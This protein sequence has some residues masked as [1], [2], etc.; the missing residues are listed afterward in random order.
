MLPGQRVITLSYHHIS[1]ARCLTTNREEAFSIHESKR[2]F[3]SWIRNS[4]MGAANCSHHVLSQLWYE[5]RP[6]YITS[7]LEIGHLPNVAFSQQWLLKHVLS[8]RNSALPN[9]YDITNCNLESPSSIQFQS[10]QYLQVHWESWSAAL[11]LVERS[12]RGVTRSIIIITR[13][14]FP[15]PEPSV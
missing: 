6:L 11:R 4:N 8:P 1:R 3:T 7:A 5:S 9:I 2:I 10:Y 14:I 13:H 15:K 12:R